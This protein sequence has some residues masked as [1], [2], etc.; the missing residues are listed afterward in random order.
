MPSLPSQRKESLLG[1][2]ELYVLELLR[3]INC[4]REPEFASG[5]SDVCIDSQTTRCAGAKSNLERS[6]KP[7]A[8][9]EEG[10]L[11]LMGY[12]K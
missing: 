2:S 1:P 12:C 8:H 11:A 3:E 6:T 5:R 10:H 9:D 7:V 4:Q